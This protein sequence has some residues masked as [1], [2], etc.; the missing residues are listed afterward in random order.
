M[1]NQNKYK[2]TKCNGDAYLGYSN[3]WV[4]KKN[5]IKKNERL[6]RKCAIKIIPIQ[7]GKII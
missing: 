5:L 4:G 7:V 6:C 3:F 1:G 2:C